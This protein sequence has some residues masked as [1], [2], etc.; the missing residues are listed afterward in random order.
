L[1]KSRL[2][3]GETVAIFGIG[4]LGIS[5]VQLAYT[6]GALDVYAIDINADKLGLAEKYGAIPVN[7]MSNDPVSEIRTLTHGK[8]VDSAGS[9][10]SALTQGGSEVRPT[11]AWDGQGGFKPSDF[12]LQPVQDCSLTTL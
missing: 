10:A 9:Q 11:E 4:G 7:A 12:I 2:K 5:A 3:V 6:F 1:R 8:G